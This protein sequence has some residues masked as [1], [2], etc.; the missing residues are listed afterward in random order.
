M[1]KLILFG[2]GGVGCALL[3]MLWTPWA[4]KKFPVKNICIF[5]P[6]DLSS[7]PKVFQLIKKGVVKHIQIEITKGNLLPLLED[8]VRPKDII[9]DVSYNIYFKPLI[10]WCINHNV[11]YIN[12]SMERW[13]IKNENILGKNLYKRTL[14]HLHEIV[15]KMNK[16]DKQYPTVVVEHGMNPGLITHFT[17]QGIKNVAKEVIDKA[18]QNRTKNKKIISLI[19][20]YKKDNFP[21]MGFLLGLETVHCS[22]RDTQISN[23]ERRSQEFMN[24]WG[25]YSFYGEGVDPVQLG[26]GTHERRLHN[27]SHPPKGLEQNQI[28][29]PIRGVDLILQSYVPIEKGTIHG[30]AISHGENDTIGR[31]LSLYKN[32]KLIYRPSNYYVYSPCEEAWNSIKEVQQ[33]KYKMLETQ[34]PLRGWEISSGVDAVGALLIFKHDP[35]EYLLYNKEGSTTSYWAGTILSI[36]EVRDLGIQ[37]AGPTVIQVAISLIAVLVWIKQNPNNGICFP[38]D[39]PYDWV[40][41]FCHQWLGTVF[42]D[43]VPYSPKSTQLEA[44]LTD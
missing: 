39:L 20:A 38:E 24:T 21:L 18:K 19:K 34:H 5:D 23:V 26:Y 10:Q 17:K 37:Y 3:E 41:D 6:R 32:K 22:E 11:R 43:W 40:L 28:F 35:I 31:S 15:K 2:C 42:M 1:A 14:Y 44:F 25:A 36:D 13:P 27:S 4:K 16:E 12:T 33:N 30:M 7:E 29:L 9:V 8:N